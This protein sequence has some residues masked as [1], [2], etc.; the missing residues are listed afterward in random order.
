MDRDRKLIVVGSRVPVPS[1]QKRPIMVNG[2]LWHEVL[3]FGNA[4]GTVQPLFHIDMFVSL[5]GRDVNGTYTVM[6]GSPEMAASI[7]GEPLPEG[8]MQ[9]VFDDVAA[10]LSALGFKVI[11]NPLPMAY[12]DDDTDNTRYWYFATGNNVLTQDGPKKVWIP[13]YGHG[14]WTKLA[15]TDA[16][17]KRIWE[18]LGYTVELLPDFHPFAANLG[19]AH[20]IKKYLGRA[21]GMA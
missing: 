16:E 9:D 10:G 12:D 14:N 4:P 18:S 17:N 3:Y 15:A 7:L 13:T 11:R 20:C 5:A 2:E 6:V 8:A 21:A 1:N 19:A